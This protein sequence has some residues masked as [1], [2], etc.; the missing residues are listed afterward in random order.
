MN[1]KI[2]KDLIFPKGEKASNQVFVWDARVQTLVPW[3]NG[4]NCPI[5]NVTFE[6]WARNNWHKHPWWQILLI[7]EGKWYY[8]EKGEKAQVI[9]KWDVVLIKPDVE[10]WH[11]ASADSQLIHLAISTNID[12]WIVEWWKPVLDEEYNNLD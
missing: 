3:D 12:K 5:Y 1:D 10:H 7:T 6:P 9:K 11:G 2:K 4:F 8:Q